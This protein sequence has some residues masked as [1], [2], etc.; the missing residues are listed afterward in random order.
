MEN[1][2]ILIGYSG[3]SFV[4]HDIFT[5][6]SRNVFAYCDAGQKEY[7]PFSLIY[8]GNENQSISDLQKNNFFISIGD[9]LIRRKIYNSLAEQNLFPINAIH[10]TSIISSSTEI[11]TNGVMISAGCIIN[12]LVKIGNGTICNT[13]SIIEHECEIENFAHIGPGAVLCGN[14]QVGENSFIGAGAVIRQ[15][16]KIGKNV[17]VG[18]GAVVVKDVVD[19]ATV[20]GCPAK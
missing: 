17:I 9:N 20:I 12:P 4:V 3:H 18:A 8:L 14:V 5:S 6:L 16:I 15:G 7:N 13:G 19:N 10:S 11:Q 2:I 1:K